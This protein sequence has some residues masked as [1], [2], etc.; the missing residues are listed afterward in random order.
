[1]LNNFLG[2]VQSEDSSTLKCPTPAEATECEFSKCP[3]YSFNAFMLKYPNVGTELT[4]SQL[5]PPSQSRTIH[6]QLLQHCHISS[7]RFL[8]CCS[9]LREACMIL[10]PHE[11]RKQVLSSES[12]EAC[13]LDHQGI[14]WFLY[15]SSLR[16]QKSKSAVT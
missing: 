1:M 8:F 5:V 9:P 12:T 14:P 15:I 10:V 6:P 11:G 16:Y 2:I 4:G 13:P 3:I 7:V